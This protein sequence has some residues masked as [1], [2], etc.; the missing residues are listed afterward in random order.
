MASKP[1][2]LQ[3]KNKSFKL[4]AVEKRAHASPVQLESRFLSSLL[5]M[6]SEEYYMM[7]GILAMQRITREQAEAIKKHASFVF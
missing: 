6:P 2:P 4:D 1:L 7:S 5:R 3:Q